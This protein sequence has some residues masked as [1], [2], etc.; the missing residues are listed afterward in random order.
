MTSYMIDHIWL[1][2]LFHM[3]RVYD[4]ISIGY[5][6]H[7]V[8]YEIICIW[9]SGM[10]S[11]AYETKHVIIYEIIGYHGSRWFQWPWF[12]NC[13]CIANGWQGPG[14]K[15]VRWNFTLKAVLSRAKKLERHV[16]LDCSPKQSHCMNVSPSHLRVNIWPMGFRSRKTSWR[17]NDLYHY[18]CGAVGFFLPMIGEVGFSFN[19]Y[20]FFIGKVGISSVVNLGSDFCHCIPWV[21]TAKRCFP[22]TFGTFGNYLLQNSV[23]HPN[24]DLQTATASL[25]GSDEYGVVAS[26]IRL[27]IALHMSDSEESA[28]RWLFF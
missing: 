21:I 15:P 11:Y 24:S 4:I 18:R 6:C 7:I 13:Q 8:M 23:S 19:C 10:I 12:G 17:Y 22:S 9:K 27:H 5:H 14:L 3:K 1:H 2:Y 20:W 28:S 25:V 26:F 16:K